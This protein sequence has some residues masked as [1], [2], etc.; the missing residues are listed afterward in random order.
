VP[1]LPSYYGSENEEGEERSIAYQYGT[2]CV[3]N[4]TSKFDLPHTNRPHYCC[5]RYVCLLWARL[6]TLQTNLAIGSV[7]ILS[8]S[9]F[10]CGRMLVRNLQSVFVLLLGSPVI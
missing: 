4:F 5:M 2:F 10:E 9:I 3:A 1:T 7:R 8:A 6:P